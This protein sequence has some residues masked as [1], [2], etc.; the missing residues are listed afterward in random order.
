MSKATRSAFEA[1]ATYQPKNGHEPRYRPPTN[2][3]Y[4]SVTRFSRDRWEITNLIT[5]G[6]LLARLAKAGIAYTTADLAPAIG[7]SN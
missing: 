3:S 7:Y 1:A 6:R 5:P 4:R 2:N